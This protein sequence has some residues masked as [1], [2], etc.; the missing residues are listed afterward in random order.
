MRASSVGSTGPTRERSRRQRS[1]RAHCCNGEVGGGG[2]GPGRL[3]RGLGELEGSRRVGAGRAAP[4]QAR[5]EGDP[6]YGPQLGGHAA[7]GAG[8]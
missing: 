1:R 8:G 3:S 6:R 4:S 7:T 2:R 5:L